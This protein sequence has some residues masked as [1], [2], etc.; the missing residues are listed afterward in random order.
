MNRRSFLET[1]SC[2]VAVIATAPLSLQSAELP[3]PSAKKLPRWRGFNLLEKFVQRKGGNPPFVEDDFRMIADFGFNFV[4]LPMSYL[5][6]TDAEDWRKLSREEELKHID[7]AVGFGRKHRIHVNINFHRGPGYCVNPPKEKLDLWTNAEAQ[8]VCALHWAAIARRYKGVPNDQV[9]FDLLNEPADIKEEVYAKVVRQLVAAIRA[10]DAQRLVIADGLKW[11]TQPVLSLADL[12]IGQSTRGYNPMEI[13]HYQA[14]WV[15]TAGQ[16]TPQW[17]RVMLSGGTLASPAKG[18]DSH[19]IL[20]DGSFATPTRMRLRVGTVS[21]ASTLLVEADGNA[22]LNKEF[23]PGP[24]EG[25]WKKVVF[26]PEWKIYQNIYDR[27]YTAEIPAGTKQLKVHVPKGDWV[28]VG[29]I[30][31]K[32]EGA[33]REDVLTIVG[34]WGEKPEPMRYAPGA[35]S[36][37]TG[38]RARDAAWLWQ[39][40]IEP[41]KKLE[42]LGVG[43]HVGE[44]GAFNKTP[45]D[46]TLRWMEDCLSNWKKA[47]WGWAMWNF[48]GAFGP[49]DSGRADVAYEEF[50]G[51]K[52]DRKMMDLIQRH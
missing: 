3:M 30:G 15:N 49:L 18:K 19:A 43:V 42:A 2:A 29:E 23:K 1:T 33:A 37:F 21:S 36:P 4:R 17:P 6:W 46:V 38:P 16:P 45:H 40:S 9:S 25:E 28:Q 20:I 13:S 50:H 31:F 44:W 35:A 11:G 39:Q 34:G 10:E 7:E 47:G 32:P 22:V 14:S 24:G 5:C 26:K 8:E 48:R 52:L 27:D 12:G 51:R 41:W